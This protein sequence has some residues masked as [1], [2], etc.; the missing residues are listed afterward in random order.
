MKAKRVFDIAVFGLCLLTADMFPLC[1]S[2]ENNITNNL[3]QSYGFC[4]RFT[5]N[6]GY[7][8]FNKAKCGGID[9]NRSL[10]E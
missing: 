2:I 6:S 3:F 1:V 8:N 10:E 7:R 4:K 5:F 9:P